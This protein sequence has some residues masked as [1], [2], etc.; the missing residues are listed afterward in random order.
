MT[1]PVFFCRRPLL[2]AITANVLLSVAIPMM[3]VSR[4]IAGL[5][6]ALADRDQLIS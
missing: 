2:R 6:L 3:R 5:A 1:C 4:A